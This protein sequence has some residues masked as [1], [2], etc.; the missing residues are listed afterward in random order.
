MRIE[1]FPLEFVKWIGV[2]LIGSERIGSWFKLEVSSAPLPSQP[3]YSLLPDDL[4]QK[5]FNP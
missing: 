1:H 5:L 4:N 3:S 2:I